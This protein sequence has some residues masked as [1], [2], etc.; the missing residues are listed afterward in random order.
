MLKNIKIGMRVKWLDKP[1]SG[2]VQEVSASRALVLIDDGFE[3]WEQI[4]KLINALD[5]NELDSVEIFDSK[6]EQKHVEVRPIITNEIDLHIENLYVDWKQIPKNKIL[7]RQLLA[8]KEEFQ[9]CIKDNVDELIVIHGKGSGILKENII[10]FLKQ[11]TAKSYEE[12]TF[13]KY[14]QAAIKIYF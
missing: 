3:E 8:F 10:R 14:R 1:W 6:N 5:T 4:S 12:M 13:G 11:V 7:E 2:I 9:M